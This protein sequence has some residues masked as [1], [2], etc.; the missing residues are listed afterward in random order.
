MSFY[1]RSSVQLCHLFLTNEFVD[2][3]EEYLDDEIKFENAGDEW[4]Q[5][6]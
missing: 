6:F 3:I 4:G 1:T 2:G 5:K